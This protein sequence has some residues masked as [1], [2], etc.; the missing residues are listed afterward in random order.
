MSR[1]WKVKV[2]FKFSDTVWVEAD[3]EEEAEALALQE[4]EL[5]EESY[6]DCEIIEVTDAEYGYHS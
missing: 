6:E 1:K 4:S 2:E 3:N 5:R